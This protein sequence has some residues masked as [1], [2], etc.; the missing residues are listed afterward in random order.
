[1]KMIKNNENIKTSNTR[2]I[3]KENLKEFINSNNKQFNQEPFLYEWI[4]LL[5]GNVNEFLRDDLNEE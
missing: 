1:M 3:R 5:D 4:E 2:K